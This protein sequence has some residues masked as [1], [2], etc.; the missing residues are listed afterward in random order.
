M[1]YTVSIETQKLFELW[2]SVHRQH[3]TCYSLCGKKREFFSVQILASSQNVTEL[4]LFLP[5]E[6]PGIHKTSVWELSLSQRFSFQSFQRV[7]HFWAIAH[8]KIKISLSKCHT[9]LSFQANVTF[10]MN[11]SKQ[12][13]R[14]STWLHSVML[15]HPHLPYMYVNKTLN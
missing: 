5:W 11:R 13:N 3:L 9:L 10:F 7:V 15:D 4:F 6:Y 2:V 1:C 8:P 14:D 12:L